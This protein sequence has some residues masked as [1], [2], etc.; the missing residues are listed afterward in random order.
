MKTVQSQNKKSFRKTIFSTRSLFIIYILLPLLIV[1]VGFSAW[2]TIT[3]NFSGSITSSID[4]ERVIDTSALMN[5][6]RF[7]PYTK[8]LYFTGAVGEDGKLQN[9]LHIET[10]IS[11]ALANIYT[12]AKDCGKNEMYLSLTLSLTT[13]AEC[14]IFYDV[15]NETTSFGFACEEKESEKLAGS[16]IKLTVRK[17]ENQPE[18]TSSS[19]TLVLLLDFS[20]T[21]ANNPFSENVEMKISPKFVLNANGYATFFDL[22]M[23]N[24]SFRLDLRLSENSP[25]TVNETN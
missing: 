21:T 12:V 22:A 18:A 8:Q 24:T 14:P 16:N 11:L 4:A 10:D 13:G 7:E 23:D 2:S 15:E 1:A 3:P 17:S 19:V 5:I 20:D 9:E 6:E 25:L